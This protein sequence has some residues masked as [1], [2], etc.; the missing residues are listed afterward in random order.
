[1]ASDVHP[2]HC[3]DIWRNLKIHGHIY[4]F[5]FLFEFPGVLAFM[6]VFLVLMLATCVGWFSWALKGPGRFWKAFV[7]HVFLE[8]SGT[9]L[10]FFVARN[11]FLGAYATMAA[12]HHFKYRHVQTFHKLIRICLHRIDACSYVWL[13]GTRVVVLLD[14]RT[15]LY[16]YGG[17]GSGIWSALSM[18]WTCV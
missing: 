5:M 13:L 11:R 16:G 2:C 7:I 6:C 4:S 18:I 8:R 10:L 14:K 1:M 9:F 3:E 15:Y 17:W 12:I